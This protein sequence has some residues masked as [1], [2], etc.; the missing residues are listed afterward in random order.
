MNYPLTHFFYN[1]NSAI[2]NNSDYYTEKTDMDTK[3]LNRTI[4][5][6]TV[7]AMIFALPAL[8]IFLG[9]YYFT[10]N[11]IVGAILGFGMHFVTLA[12]SGRISKWLLKIMS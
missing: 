2:I 8:G 10:G 9:I 4:K 1:K 7:L 12:F 3:I 6:S 11:L 5:I